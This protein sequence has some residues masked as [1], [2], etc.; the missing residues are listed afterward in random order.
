MARGVVTTID[1]F[2]QKVGVALDSNLG[3]VTSGMA[4]DVGQSLLHNAK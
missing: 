3:L 4:W 2:Q 1:N